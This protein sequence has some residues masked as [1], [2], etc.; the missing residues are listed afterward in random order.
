VLKT[1]ATPF[2]WCGTK[3]ADAVNGFVEVFEDHDRLA[4][5][6]E[7]LKAT[8]ESL[9]QKE[10]DEA[11]LREEN[12]WLK[13]YL[14]LAQ[15]HPELILQDARVI[16]RATD[17]YSTVLTLNRGSVHGIKKN[18][19]VLTSDGVLGCVKEVG[20]DWCKVT[21]ILET[22][23][24]VG[25][26]T[27]RTGAVGVVQGDLDLRSQ[28]RC[29]MLYIDKTAELKPG[30]RVYTKGGEGSIYPSDLLIGEIVS[31][32]A[33]EAGLWVEILPAVSPEE[34]EAVSRLMI[35]CGYDTEG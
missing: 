25:A 1:I 21:S 15:D 26:Y 30:D 19:P 27:D 18:M 24:S 34:I 10:Q 5:E 28:G 3:V 7:D 8:V 20:L 31:I 17:N 9:E 29:R 4:S 14:K 32:Q 2:E 22:S 12:A 35:V 16:A 23:S 33:D 13:E 11:L 6:N